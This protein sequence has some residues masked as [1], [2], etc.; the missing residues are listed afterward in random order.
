MTPDPEPYT[1][2]A[3][4][5]GDRHA[6]RLIHVLVA[7]IAGLAGQLLLYA[8]ML[9]EGGGSFLELNWK[10]LAGIAGGGIVAGLAVLPFRDLKLHQA[11]GFGFL[12]SLLVL[13]GIILVDVFVLT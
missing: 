3:A 7:T 9:H 4:D 1:P 6:S 8:Y 12:I 10:D 2:P 13:C 11:A 5:P